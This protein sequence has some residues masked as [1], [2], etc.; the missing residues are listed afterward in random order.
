MKTITTAIYG[1][2][3]T[4]QEPWSVEVMLSEP[5]ESPS[6]VGILIFALELGVQSR[7]VMPL[8]QGL[9]VSLGWGPDGS[10][11]DVS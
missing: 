5:S 10:C 1:V 7:E 8:V 3:A 6:E 4:C 11:L 2:P 9:M